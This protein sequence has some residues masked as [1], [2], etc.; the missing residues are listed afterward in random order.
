MAEVLASSLPSLSKCELSEKLSPLTSAW[1][2][3]FSFL[4]RAVQWMLS[5]PGSGGSCTRC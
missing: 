1:G 3:L 5:A 2:T 4:Q